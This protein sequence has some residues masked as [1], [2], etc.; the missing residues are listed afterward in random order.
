MPQTRRRQQNNCRR[1]GNPLAGFAANATN[2]EYLN[3]AIAANQQ[4]L[5][6][7][8]ACDPSY[9]REWNRFK[10]FVHD[11][12]TCSEP[13]FQRHNI[14][15]YYTVDVS[16][17]TVSKNSLSRVRQALNWYKTTHYPEFFDFSVKSQVTKQAEDLQQVRKKSGA[18]D[19]PGKDPHKGLKDR[20]PP[21]KE[22]K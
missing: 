19:K 17:R 14:D 10:K 20:L 2:E 3:Q 5:R 7:I 21:T 15:T 9:T 22:K 8:A 18:G 16:K 1:N 12:P 6:M 11:N 4:S 13:F